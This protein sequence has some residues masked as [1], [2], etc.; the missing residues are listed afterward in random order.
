[1]STTLLRLL[2]CFVVL[3]GLAG[4]LGLAGQ[5]YVTYVTHDQLSIN[6][7]A[8]V[9][10]AVLGFCPAFVVYLLWVLIAYAARSMRQRQPARNDRQA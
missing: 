9:G 4:L 3:P 10:M 8:V 5:I 2:V 7:G 1:M 6:L